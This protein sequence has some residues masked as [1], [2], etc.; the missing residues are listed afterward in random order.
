MEETGLIN[1]VGEWVIR[2]ACKQNREWQKAGANITVSVNL[3]VRQF[4]EHLVNIVYD[5]LTEADLKPQFLELEV[6]ESTIMSDPDAAV[7]I[8]QELKDVGV[9]VSI[10]DFGTGYSSLN[11]LRRLPLNFLKIDRSFVKN[12]SL[13]RS[14]EAIIKTI[15]TLAHSLNLA[16]VAEGVETQNQLD[17]LVQAGCDEIQGYLLS[18]PMPVDKAREYI[19]KPRA[20]ALTS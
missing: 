20:G 8:L 14:D 12:I 15:I 3:S 17:F 18:P 5:A 16:T 10:D 11:Y 13:I 1:K 4:D 2:T 7:T 19:F 6:T 9:R